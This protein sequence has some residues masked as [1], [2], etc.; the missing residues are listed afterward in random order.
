MNYQFT[1]YSLVLIA[2]TTIALVVAGAV[3]RRRAVPGAI[4]LA[5]LELVDTISRYN[6]DRIAE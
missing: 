6:R 3:W 5:F 2:T 1:S 4:Y